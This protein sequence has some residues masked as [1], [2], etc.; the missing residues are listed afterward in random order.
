MDPAT[1]FLISREIGRPSDVADATRTQAR[2]VAYNRALEDELP[3]D[4]AVVIQQRFGYSEAEADGV[5]RDV[6]IELYGRQPGLY[7]QTSLALLGDLLIGSEQYLGGQ[8][9]AGGVRRY[10]NPQE[11]YGDWWNERVRHL[12]QPASPAEA[13]EFR[14]AQAVANIFQ[15]FRYAPLLLGLLAIGLVAAT[16]V[17]GWRL[18]WLP[19]GM[20]LWLLLLTAFLSGALERYRYP[21]DPLLAVGMGGGVAA[22]A[23]GVA[24]LASRVRATRQT[25]STTVAAPTPA[26]TSPSATVGR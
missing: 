23:V 17:P 20:G 3:S 11:K 2:R 26:S 12:A 6:A 19:V 15:P 16:V 22:L 14:R 10:P 25:P 5:L 1:P 21:A 18:A 7:V 24:R 4:I 13:N 9:K 8:G